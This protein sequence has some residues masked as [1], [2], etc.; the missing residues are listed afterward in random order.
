MSNRAEK[1]TM[2][3]L[4]GLVVVDLSTYLSGPVCSML[5]ADYGADVIKV[6]RPGSGDEVRHFKPFLNGVSSAFMLLNRNKRSIELDLKKPED[7]AAMQRLIA[8]ADVL[9]ENFRPGVCDRLGIG[10]EAMR[11]ANPQLV[12]CSISGFGQ[13]GPYRER[14]GFDLMAQGI[15][16]L[17]SINALPDGTPC[18]LPIPISD[19]CAGMYA[20]NAVCTALLARNRTGLGQAVDVSLLDVAVS[21]G[22]YEAATH[23]ATGEIPRSIGQG[24][25]TMAP[26]QAFK[27]KDGWLTLGAGAQGLWLKLCSVLDMHELVNDARFVDAVARARHREE[28]AERINARVAMRSRDEWLELLEKAGIPAGPVFG[29]DEVF[30]DPQIIAREMVAEVEH[31]QAGRTRMLGVVAKLSDTPGCV[32]RPAPGLGEHS[33]EIKGQFNIDR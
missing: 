13:T 20:S 23:L 22:I 21:L 32:R 4:A 27:A 15:A 5:L 8:C 18:R 3:A 30:R 31:P 29:Y 17:M 33:L 9:I 1:S 14:G 7:L 26:Y 11:R 16:G 25:R 6:E 2:G 28:L 10:Q 19:L 24:H 12:Y